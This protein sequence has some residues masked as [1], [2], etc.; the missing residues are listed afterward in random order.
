MEYLTRRGITSRSIPD[1][2]ADSIV[3]ECE[4][5]KFPRHLG[6]KASAMPV[7]MNGKPYLNDSVL[8]GRAKKPAGTDE[9]T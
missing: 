7:W 6:C 8:V 2:T 3:F 5:D 4:S 9:G 1:D